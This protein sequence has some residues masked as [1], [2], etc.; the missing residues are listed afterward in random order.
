MNQYI[1]A[2]WMWLAGWLAGYVCGKLSA[3]FLPL[4]LRLFFKR[5]RHLDLIE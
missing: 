1:N 2:E 4:S 5:S 3:A